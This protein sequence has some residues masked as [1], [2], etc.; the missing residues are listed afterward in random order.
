MRTAKDRF[1]RALH[2][3]REWCRAHRHA[4]IEAQHR[5]LVRKLSGHYA[6]FGVTHN[7][8]ALGRFRYEVTRIW[9]EWLSRRSQK[10][11]PD[12]GGNASAAAS[13]IRFRDRALSH[14]FG[15]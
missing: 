12:V 3:I 5:A 6:Y 2:R 15:T 13:G 10:R 11:R 1:S 8:D 4:D 7:S 14:R 9:R